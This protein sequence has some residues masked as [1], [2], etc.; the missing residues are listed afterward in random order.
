M[1]AA[2]WQRGEEIDYTNT[3]KAT[4]QA[5]T[6]VTIGSRIGIVG[7]DILPGEIGALHMNGVFA[8]PKADEGEI[9]AGIDVYFTEKGITKS[10]DNGKTSGEKVEYP[11]AGYLIETAAA[12]DAMAKVKLL[13]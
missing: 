3:T 13:G 9:A 10:A 5:N 2:F 7:G 6:I 1:K 11:K 12:S 8:I 4:I